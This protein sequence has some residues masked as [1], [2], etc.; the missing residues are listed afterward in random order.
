M[1]FTSSTTFFSTTFLNLLRRIRLLCGWEGMKRDVEVGVQAKVKVA[2]DGDR[3]WKEVI[4]VKKVIE[5]LPVPIPTIRIFSTDGSEIPDDASPPPAPKVIPSAN[6]SD[7]APRSPLGDMTNRVPPR[8]HGRSPGARPRS[9]AFR[10]PNPRE[11]REHAEWKEKKAKATLKVPRAVDG[12]PS[13]A[14]SK[15]KNKSK[16]PAAVLP[17][18]ASPSIISPAS[19]TWYDLKAKLLDDA[20]AQNKLI[21]DKAERRRSL[22]APATEKLVS[23][24]ALAHC[25]SVPANISSKNFSVSFSDRLR[26]AFSWKVADKGAIPGDVEAQVFPIEEPV[27][28][29]ISNPTAP[30]DLHWS[31]IVSLDDY[32]V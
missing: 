2:D 27:N 5:A 23:A 20:R 19:D 1:T 15:P 18:P 3:A 30:E 13:F 8:I 14:P 24:A 11:V 9:S 28:F 6:D 21:Q 12:N 29:S 10:K 31:D 16:T 26:R 7:T 22:P 17:P 25:A 4:E 32:L